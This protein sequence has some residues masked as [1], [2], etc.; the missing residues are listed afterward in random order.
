MM[1]FAVF[2]LLLYSWTYDAGAQAKARI[3]NL[4]FIFTS[5]A[6][7]GIDRASFRGKQSVDGH[8]VNAALI[9]EINS[10]PSVIFPH[11][12][13]VL[14]GQNAGIV[15]FIVE[16]GDIANRMEKPHQSAAISWKQFDTDYVRGITLKNHFGKPA[17]LLIVPGNHD[18]SDAIGYYKPMKPNTD[19]TSMANIFNLMMKPVI[20]LTKEIYNYKN[21][22][23]NY[24]KN[25]DGIHFMFI[26]LWPDSIAKRMDGKRF[27]I[28]I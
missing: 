20:P 24:S 7:Y 22:K 17:E 26:T 2:L 12:N 15:E 27:A 23:I 11:D 3:H 18:I 16:G 9:Q 8:I 1:K 19:A 5:E 13:G 21:N 6:H 14:A 4:Q 28:D 10:L 25:I